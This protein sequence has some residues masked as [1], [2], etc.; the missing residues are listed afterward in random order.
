MPWRL[1]GF[2][3]IFAIF[4]VFIAFNLGNKCDISFGFKTFT[5]V[6]VFLTAFSSFIVGML[7]ALPIA[8]KSRRKTG[9]E[10]EP[11]P[12]KKGGEKLEEIVPEGSGFSDNGPYGIN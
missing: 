4:L 10:A 2:I 8:I 7:C 9:K 5:E 11:K 1:I 3:I 6:P 12:K